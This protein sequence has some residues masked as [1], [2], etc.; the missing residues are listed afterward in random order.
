LLFAK[1]EAPIKGQESGVA[2][3]AKFFMK[4]NWITK[5]IKTSE[6]YGEKEE[7]FEKRTKEHIERVQNAAKR[8]VESLNQFEGVLEQVKHHDESK[9]KEPERTPYI[10]ITWK[11]K[12][13]R[14]NGYKKPVTLPDPK[15]T[16][17]TVHH[18]VNNEH[19]PEYWAPRAD[20][21]LDPKDRSKNR[22]LVD[23][24]KMNDVSIVEMVADWVAISEELQN[25]TPRE[26][27]NSQKD[28]RWH[29]SPYQEKLIDRCLRVFENSEE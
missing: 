13:D 25:N 4:E 23:A 1:A 9:L 26:W 6:N 18:I 2:S 28:V 17:A 22:K 11:H 12:T 19:H 7:Y 20:V 16:A 15:E 14:C 24:T 27:F 10:A 5:L 8:I 3:T 21:D 29:F